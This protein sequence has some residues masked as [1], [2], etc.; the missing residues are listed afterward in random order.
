M[1]FKEDEVM[2]LTLSKRP[3]DE[4]ASP[5]FCAGRKLGDVAQALV[6]T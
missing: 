5:S 6:W 3:L 1:S 4:G 2:P